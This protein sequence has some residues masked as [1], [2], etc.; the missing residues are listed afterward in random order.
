MQSCNLLSV[1][2][3]AAI[4][5]NPNESGALLGVTMSTGDLHVFVYYY[6]TWVL[7]LLN[8]CGTHRCTQ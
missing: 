6:P 3:I 5:I 2:A 4:G 1:L 8:G 7:L